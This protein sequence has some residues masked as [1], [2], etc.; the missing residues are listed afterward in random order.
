MTN[1]KR[2][3]A[4]LL[5]FLVIASVYPTAVPTSYDVTIIESDTQHVMSAT[6]LVVTVDA[7]D[8]PMDFNDDD[9]LFT[10]MNG[11]QAISGATVTITNS[12]DDSVYDVPV[13]TVGDGTAWFHDVPIG[14]WNWNVT[15]ALAP[16]VSEVGTINSDGPQVLF[17]ELLGNIDG[18]NDDD[19]LNVTFTDVDGDIAV[20]LN[21]TMINYT[22]P[23]TWEV[24]YQMDLGSDGLASYQDIAIGNYS[25]LITVDVGDYAGTILWQQNFTTDGTSL[26][27]KQTLNQFTG[28]P[29]YQDLDIYVYW[30]TTLDP[31]EGAVIDLMYY[32]GS[33]IDS[34]ITTLNGSI[35]F[36]DLPIDAINVTITYGGDDIGVGNWFYNLTLL[37][38][39]IRSPTV[40]GTERI[41]ELEGTHNITI[42]WQIYDEFPSSLEVFVDDISNT[43]I[44]WTNQTEYTFNATGMT[45]GEYEI[46]L[47]ASDELGSQT[48]NI[49]ILTIYEDVLPV[50]D[51]PDDVE[52]YWTE[53]GYTL[54]W[55]VTDEYMNKYNISLDGEEIDAGDLDPDNPFIEIS[56]NDLGIGVH[57]YIFIANDTS[58]NSESDPVTVT[59]IADDVVPV[60]TYAPD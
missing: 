49:T 32:N 47:V 25:W 30:E 53:T 46:K 18:Q 36:V 10:V 34:R 43:T 14:I 39:D 60:I 2:A 6:T 58:G 13:G 4:I 28:S 29:D 38:F 42:T 44:D 35:Q 33:L 15:W 59:V 23:T 16:G 54:L 12:T 21:F 52:F 27:A 7:Q 37:A 45:I 20:G 8:Q 48:E 31:L 55:N 40:N 19:D 56:L 1:T 9:F 50:I 3:F 11:T 41:S 5:T 22:S 51:G 26:Y 57:E 17:D 24:L